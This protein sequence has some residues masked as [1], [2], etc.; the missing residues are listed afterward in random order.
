MKPLLL[1]LALLAGVTPATVASSFG[2]TFVPPNLR[3]GAKRE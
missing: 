2:G 3:R 1:A